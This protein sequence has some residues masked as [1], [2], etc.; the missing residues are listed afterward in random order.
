MSPGPGGSLAAVGF[1][2]LLAAHVFLQIVWPLPASPPAPPPPV[3]GACFC[4]CSGPEAFCPA[5]G[6]TLPHLLLAAA[7]GAAL[8]L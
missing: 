8:G 3:P 7:A 4:D 2:A 6:Y 5:A 1:V